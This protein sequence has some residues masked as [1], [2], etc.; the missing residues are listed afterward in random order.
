MVA[1][2]QLL[3]FLLAYILN[4]ISKPCNPIVTS[5]VDFVIKL[6]LITENHGLKFRIGEMK[7][8]LKDSSSFLYSI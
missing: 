6:K 1:I 5:W 8:D 3:G 4:V 7:A 2:L